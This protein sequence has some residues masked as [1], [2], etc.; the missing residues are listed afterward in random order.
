MAYGKQYLR[1]KDSKIY[2]DFRKTSNQLR[3]LTKKFV[4]EKGFGSV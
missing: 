3:H 1:T 2:S 4:I